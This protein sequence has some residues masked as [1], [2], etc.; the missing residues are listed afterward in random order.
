MRFVTREPVVTGSTSMRTTS[1]RARIGREPGPGA[2]SSATYVP[3]AS[4]TVVSMNNP[5][6]LRFRLSSAYDSIGRLR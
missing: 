2:I 4:A 3:S 1:A 5:P 6:V